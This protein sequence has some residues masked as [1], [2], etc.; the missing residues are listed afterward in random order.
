VRF[1]G[2]QVELAL[3]APVFRLLERSG[4]L[5]QGT[6]LACEVRIHGKTVDAIALSPSG[7]LS[8]FEFKYASAPRAVRQAA[9][10]RH[11]V[12]RSYVVLGRSP[13]MSSIELATAV[14][15]GVLVYDADAER[16]DRRAPAPTTPRARL[17]LRSQVL[18]RVIE[19]GSSL[20]DAL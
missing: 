20:H 6:L 9:L 3:Y 1:A 12:D 13:A 8:G 17:P 18:A 10:N 14:G 4:Q 19:E 2:A 16:L 5:P 15:V 7:I 11:Y